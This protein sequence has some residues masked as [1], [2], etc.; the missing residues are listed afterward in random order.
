MLGQYQCR[1]LICVF[2]YIFSLK[3]WA[4]GIILSFVG[5]ENNS[6]ESERVYLEKQPTAR[7]HFRRLIKAEGALL[8]IA[9]TPIIQVNDSLSREISNKINIIQFFKKQKWCP[10]LTMNL[11]SFKLVIMRILEILGVSLKVWKHP[12]L[13][14][15]LRPPWNNKQRFLKMSL[16]FVLLFGMLWYDLDFNDGHFFVTMGW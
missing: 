4:V 8:Y 13:E 6:R 3:L 10:D 5:L 14:N 12:Q 1:N 11:Q 7:S 16:A 15:C 2:K 9:P